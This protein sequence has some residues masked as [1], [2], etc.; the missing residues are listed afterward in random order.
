[1]LT[2][3]T[4]NITFAANNSVISFNASFASGEG[5]CN[6]GQTPANIVGC[7]H[8]WEVQINCSTSNYC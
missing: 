4:L 8:A 3:L 2:L 6:V 7:D 1:M 5:I